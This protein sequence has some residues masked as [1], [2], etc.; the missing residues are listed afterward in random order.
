MYHIKSQAH[1]IILNRYLSFMEF[2][3]LCDSLK[4]CT[5]WVYSDA[6]KEE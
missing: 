3:T 1:S 5:I 4:N 2:K 6:K